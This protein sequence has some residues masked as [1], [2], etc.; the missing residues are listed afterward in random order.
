MDEWFAA[1]A[2]MIQFDFYLRPSEIVDCKMRDVL[3]PVLQMGVKLCGLLIANSETGDVTKTGE[4]DDTVLADSV[5][6]GWISSLIRNLIIRK[7]SPDAKL[8]QNLTLPKYESLFRKVSAKLSLQSFNITPH[9]MR[10][11]GPSDDAFHK[12]R[13]LLEI[14]KRGRWKCPK[15]VA[16]Y[17]KPG[18]LLMQASKI[19]KEVWAAAAHAES[20]I[21]AVL[22]NRRWA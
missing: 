8:F 19:S 9:V 17:D 22:T 3:R 5:S 10:H 7:A 13:S 16:R 15:S 1:A 11:S 21:A 12:V 20:E 14:Q 2:V 4:Q 18:R 6:R